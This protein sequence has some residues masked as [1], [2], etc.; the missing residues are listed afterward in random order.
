MIFL[1]M[2]LVILS[3]VAI[4]NFDLHKIVYVK[5]LS[6]NAGD[7]AALAAARWQGLTLNLIGDLNL[8]QAVALTQGDT[9]AV[10][11]INGLQARLCYVGPMVGLEAAQQAAKNNGIFNNDR[12]TA[13]LR[14]HA[15]EVRNDY[16]SLGP[17]GKM[18][19][20]EPY[21]N[22]W[23]EYA[24]M[25]DVVAENGVAAGPDNARLYTDYAGEHMLLSLDF[26]DAIAGE[27]WCW[28]FHNAYDVLLNYSDYHYW[29]ALPEQIK[30]PNPINCE[31]YGLGLTK[32]QLVGTAS[33]EAR[34]N[35]LLGERFTNAAVSLSTINVT[36][37]WYCY[38]G[39]LWGP[40]EAISATGDAAFPVTGTV[41]K[42]YNYA[43]ADAAARV[44]AQASRLTP[45]SLPSKIV[46]SAAAK[47]FGYLAEDELPTAAGVVL[48]AF[49][50]TRLIPI[51]AS[52]APAGGAF[53]LD[54][55]DHIEGHLQDYMLYG[56]PKATDCW[57][58]QQLITW[59]NALFRQTGIEWLQQYSDTCHSAGGP[60][61][62]G[63]GSRR[64][65]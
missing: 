2:V 32:K 59:E 6:Q 41:K 36:S 24:D 60:G 10:E 31:Y 17:D 34:M 15:D 43:G 56:P 13:R 7:G 3:F 64:G 20:E 61:G 39:G 63:G 42:P 62:H 57:Y 4:W 1:I 21:T 44:M 45:K 19:F 14:K 48:P 8:M 58:C 18:M 51:D 47:P 23:Q 25:I 30:Q 22:C 11:A 16:T 27:D 55:R 65:H 9:G 28:F 37:V 38:E 12:F 40:W 33:L 26:Y 35:D 52:S 53:D 29:P 49:R 50:E 54:W 5:S 46:W